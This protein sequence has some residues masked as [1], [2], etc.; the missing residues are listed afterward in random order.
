MNSLS[1][2]SPPVLA[3]SGA[4]ASRQEAAWRGDDGSQS[5]S[6]ALHVGPH[7]RPRAI[8]DIERDFVQA[9]CLTPDLDTRR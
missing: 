1:S 3:P 7:S 5:A 9:L 2:L 6:Q 4:G 8:D